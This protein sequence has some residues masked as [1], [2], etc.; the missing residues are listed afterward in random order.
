MPGTR[1]T[2]QEAVLER[3]SSL[4]PEANDLVVRLSEIVVDPN[5][6]DQVLNDSLAECREMHADL[7]STLKDLKEFGSDGDRARFESSLLQM[8]I[9]FA[10]LI[11][12]LTSSSM[13]RST[14]KSKFANDDDAGDQFIQTLKN[15]VISSRRPLSEPSVFNGDPLEYAV[16]KSE[17]N[18]FVEEHSINAAEKIHSL[19]KYTSGR[20]RECIEGY[21]CVFSDASYTEARDMLDKRFG[22][23]FVVTFAF[24]EKLEK[25]PK[26]GDKDHQALQKFSDFLKHIQSNLTELNTIDV[27]DDPKENYK[28]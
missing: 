14:R 5:V 28:I 15:L 26:I 10:S 21:L 18:S 17:F 6:D 27:L 16:W 22:D 2:K 25:W 12:S 23:R 1:A 9:T 7:S 19:K 24:R 8:Q 20:A 3:I 13:A 11:T 4:M